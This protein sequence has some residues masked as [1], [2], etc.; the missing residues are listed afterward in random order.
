MN[1]K[2]E[3]ENI[4]CECDQ[5]HLIPDDKLDRMIDR[6]A[7][8]CCEVLH[9]GGP[10]SSAVHFYNNY[11]KETFFDGTTYH[12]IYV[13]SVKEAEEILDQ[14][15]ASTEC[16]LNNIVRVLLKVPESDRWD[17]IGLTDKGIEEMMNKDFMKKRLEDSDE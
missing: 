9:E 5:D 15:D 6:L 8:F 1:I 17:H 4:L 7:I 16:G 14:L 13:D 3:I 11:T 2:Q 10:I 12:N